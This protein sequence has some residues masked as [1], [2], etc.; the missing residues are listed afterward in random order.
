L[1]TVF[2]RHAVKQLLRFF[3]NRFALTTAICFA[4]LG[5]AGPSAAQS[6]DAEFY[7][8]LYTL[9]ERN[10]DST[11]ALGKKIIN[12]GLPELPANQAAHFLGALPGHA[13]PVPHNGKLGNFVLSLPAEKKTCIVF[14]RRLDVQTTQT[15]F[16]QIASSPPAGLTAERQPDLDRDTEPNGRT[17]TVSFIWMDNNS[18]RRLLWLQTTALSPDAALQALT[19]VSVVSP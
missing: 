15:L 17:H 13:F 16:A 19:S 5:Y 4:A 11:E 12:K 2:Q 1:A 10:I 9:C 18:G 7:T 6:D 3:V 14:A 8:S